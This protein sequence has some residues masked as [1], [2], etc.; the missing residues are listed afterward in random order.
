MDEKALHEA[1]ENISVIKGVMERTSKSFA[2]FSRVFTYWGMLFIVNSIIT[3]MLLS[4][5]EKML[6]LASSFPLL[7]YI[8]PVGIIALIAALM[9]WNVSKKIPFVGLE[10]HLMIVWIL[11]LL[12][13]VIPPKIT[14]NSTFASADFANI[15][16]QTDKLSVVL[17]SLAIALI[18]TALFTGYKHLRNLGIIY[19]GISLIHT[20][21]GFPIFEGSTYLNLLY[22]I[23]LPF[24]FLYVGLFLRSRQIRGN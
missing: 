1:M 6:V 4:N 24:T 8:F 11:V 15:M 19:I 21:L 9:Y 7:N 17:F 3:M 13:N 18:T 14:V 2:A 20:F 22:S 12:L 5:K 23:T 10:K 16:V